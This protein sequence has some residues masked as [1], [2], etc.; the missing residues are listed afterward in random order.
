MKRLSLYLVNHCADSSSFELKEESIPDLGS[1]ELLIE[2]EASG[3][4]FA[5]IMARK[6]LY[7]DAPPL[8]AILGYE[9]A[10]KV[11]K[12]SGSSGNFKVGDFVLAFTRFGGYT[13]LAI[14]DERTVVKL[15]ES[16]SAANATALAT[17][18]VTAYYMAFYKANVISGE[19]A[20]VHA[21]AGGVGTALVQ[22]LKNAGV[23][24]AGTASTQE[25]LKFAESNGLDFGI[26]YKELDF[27]KACQE[28]PNWDKFDA[29]FDPIGGVNFK[30]NRRLLRK[31]G[32]LVLFGV[33]S[34]SSSSGSL[35]DK[36]KLA[37]SFGFIHPLS[38]LMN[39]DT[40]SGVNMLHIAEAQ[41]KHIKKCMEEVVSL[42]VEGKV[43][44]E[45][46]Y[47]YSPKDV[48]QAFDLI[49]SRKST[50]KV[51]LNWNLLR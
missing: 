17:Q 36:L 15:P 45:C 39:S 16:I 49:A 2:V 6:G 23:S 22:L 27:E 31:G 37:W 26:N 48:L 24:V 38:L 44:P 41:P 19:R 35:W 18:Y 50:G 14:A 9:V 7:Q 30:K 12:T 33:S 34:W 51:C 10:G 21:A 25:K 40:L 3:I 32:R 13:N 11:V 5:D 46:K 42:S 43:N 28:N 47:E 8:P 29:I 20:L 4:N 1:N